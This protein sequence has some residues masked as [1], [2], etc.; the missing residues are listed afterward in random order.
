[1][2]SFSVKN[3]RKFCAT[4]G[5][6]L[7]SQSRGLEKEIHH[8]AISHGNAKSSH[9]MRNSKG[10]S[11]RENLEH[12]LESFV[13]ILYIISKLEKS[14][15]QCFKQYANRSSTKKLWPFEDNCA[16]LKGISH[17]LSLMQKFS[18]WHSLMRKFLHWLSPMRKFLHSLSLMWKFS[19]CLSP[20]WN[21]SH[22][23]SL[24]LKC[25]I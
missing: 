12:F 23:L 25:N 9:A 4:L 17:H 10:N 13:Y 19:H 14:G 1:M 6:E 15:V 16:K 18:H 2:V 11:C 24:M 7:P 21:F 20:M 22:H 3:E 5:N 8:E